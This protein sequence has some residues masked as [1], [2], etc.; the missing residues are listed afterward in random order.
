MSK[1]LRLWHP[2]A[3]ASANVIQTAEGVILPGIR[4]TS[5]RDGWA[6]GWRKRRR[7]HSDSRRS[8]RSFVDNPVRCCTRACLLRVGPPCCVRGLFFVTNG[9]SVGQTKDCTC[10]VVI[11]CSR[12]ELQVYTH[13]GCSSR[14]RQGNECTILQRSRTN[15]IQMVAYFRSSGPSVYTKYDRRFVCPHYDPLFASQ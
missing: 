11:G 4:P 7:L 14:I 3:E 1:G 8:A 9:G 5:K 6:P 13:G 12:K 15:E 2:G 10:T